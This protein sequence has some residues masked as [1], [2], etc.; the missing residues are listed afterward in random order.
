MQL[1]FAVF[2]SL[3]KH[4]DMLTLLRDVA[5]G[6]LRLP[7]SST[8]WLVLLAAFA[9]QTRWVHGWTDMRGNFWE[10]RCREHDGDTWFF[11]DALTTLLGSFNVWWDM[12][13]N[14]HLD[15][16]SPFTWKSLYTYLILLVPFLNI[17]KKKIVSTLRTLPK[18]QTSELFEAKNTSSFAACRP[19]VSQHIQLFRTA[20][21]YWVWLRSSHYRCF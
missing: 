16:F 6:Y 4:P 18:P 19:V 9:I 5:G 21:S 15:I 12:K 7:F 20:G 2:F 14:N 8:W 11:W 17:F 3:R 10:G 1:F 13:E